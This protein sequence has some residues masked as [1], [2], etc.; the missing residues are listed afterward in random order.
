MRQKREENMS[1]TIDW[2]VSGIGGGVCVL[3][4]LFTLLWPKEAAA[5][6]NALLGF[7]CI[8]FG[9][10]YLLVVTSFVFFSTMALSQ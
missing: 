9:W 7:F 2:R 5:V 6:F 8:K 10:L 4:I 3:F 1:H